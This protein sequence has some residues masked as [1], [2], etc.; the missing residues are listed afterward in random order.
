MDCKVFYPPYVLQFDHRDPATKKYHVAE[1]VGPISMVMREINKCDL[2]C[3]NCHAERTMK[4]RL[5][6]EK[7]EPAIDYQLG[8]RL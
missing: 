3:A 5:E 6:I 7:L 1:I 4:R 2:V 8:L